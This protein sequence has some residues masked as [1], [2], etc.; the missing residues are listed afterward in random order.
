MQQ[1]A[2]FI[3]CCKYL[4]KAAINVFDLKKFFKKQNFDFNILRYN[5]TV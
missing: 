2:N 1:V 4:A 3:G 5:N